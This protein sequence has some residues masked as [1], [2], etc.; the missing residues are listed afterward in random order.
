MTHTLSPGFTFATLRTAPNPVM[1]PHPTRAASHKGSS[2]GI[3][4]ADASGTTAY[5]A[6]HDTKLKCLSDDASAD[7]RRMVPSSMVPRYAYSPDGS[8]SVTS[9]FRQARQ[10]P[11]NGT[12]ENDTWSPGRT[13]DTPSPTASTTP[14]PSWPNTIVSRLVPSPPSANSRSE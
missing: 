1:T 5:S 4:M 8:Q 10:R 12:M 7:C 11:Q 6:K 9:P 3:E 14:A 13:C 2:R